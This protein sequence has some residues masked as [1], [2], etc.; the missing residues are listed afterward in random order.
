MKKKEYR[1]PELKV[2]KL[3]QKAKLLEDSGYVGPLGANMTPNDLP[4]V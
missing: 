1:K 4:K 2:V 3:K